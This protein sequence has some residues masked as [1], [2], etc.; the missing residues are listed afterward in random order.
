MELS[1]FI[2]GLIIGFLVAAPVG[3]IGILCIRRSI[4]NGQLSGLLTGLGAA[5]A[6][7][8]YGAVAAFGL[9]VISQFF[10]IH[11]SA[12]ELIGIIFLI[13]LGIKSFIGVHKIKTVKESA[14]YI[15][16]YFSTFFLTLTNPITLLTFAAIF[17][18][19]GIVY[20][21]TYLSPSL[22]V[23]GVFIGSTSWWLFL[24]WASTHFRKHIDNRTFGL[25]NHVSGIL[26]LLFALAL[27]IRLV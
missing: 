26:I 23:F 5:T 21:K 27:S 18:G 10:F 22:I 6:D 13:Y 17:A 20:A 11:K 14:A 1:F 3:P 19:L 2:R 4:M 9:T 8:L 25:I 7:A 24:S 12:I 15:S 16:D